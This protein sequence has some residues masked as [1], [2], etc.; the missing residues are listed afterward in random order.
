MRLFYIVSL[1]GFSVQTP[2]A[3]HFSLCVSV[4]VVSVDLSSASLERNVFVFLLK[5]L[6]W[7]SMLFVFSFIAV[8]IVI[9]AALNSLLDRPETCFISESCCCF[10]MLCGKNRTLVPWAG[11]E[12]TPPA[13]WTLTLNHWT[14]GEVPLESCFDGGF[15][16]WECG[17]SV[18]FF[19]NA[20]CLPCN[21]FSEPHM[22]YRTVVCMPGNGRR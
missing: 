15:V 4:G 11:I 6:I 16:F 3:T 20:L 7:F 5:L 14:S 22:L 2:I 13:V 21:Y 18:F 9:V 10:A 1:S 12:P 17:V 19:F 8:N